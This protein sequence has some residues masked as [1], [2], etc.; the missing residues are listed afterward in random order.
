MTRSPAASKTA[1]PP[2]PRL[3]TTLQAA[4][5]ALRPLEFLDRC[6]RRHGDVFTLRIRRERPW[7]L[8][9]DPEHVKHV[10]TTEPALVGA[11]AAE[12]N[13]LLEPLLGPRSVM[14]LDEPQHLSDR[15]R[16][17][18][19]FHGRRM[20]DYGAMMTEVARRHVEDWPT[21][22]P[23]ELWPRMQ[24]ISL[25]VVTSAVFDGLEPER[26][27]LLRERLVELTNWINRPR[28][29][30]LLA[31]VGK[32]SLTSSAGFADAM[33]RVESVVLDEVRRRRTAIRDAA[34]DDRTARDGAAGEAGR[35]EDIHAML[36][37]S[38]G[39]D[40]PDGERKMRDELV[41]MLSDGPTATSLAWVFERL[42]RHPEKLARLREEVLRGECD[43][44]LDA[45]VKETLRL[46]PAV[47]LVMRRLIEPMRLGRHTIPADTIVAPC[48][49][50]M[51]RRAD[52]Y[53]DPLRF[54]PERFLERP[55]GTY[56][57]IPFG[58]GVRRC[59][60]ASFAQ[61]EMRRVIEVVVRELDLRAANAG[62]EAPVRSSVSFAPDGGA[63]V[64][65]TRR[66]PAP[67]DRQAVSG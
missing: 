53:R 35:H 44:Y 27:E 61:L 16:L 54:E 52:V 22:E 11:G 58:G 29:L 38:Y 7:V 64:I 23:F 8:L 36:E 12:A 56:T 13:P 55:E 67:S 34:S 65:A 20:R 43:D 17:L 3:P 21:S 32:R 47:P 51:H 49:Y 15:K 4:I 5:W 62:T 50:L 59:V 1:L 28:R 42:L 40:T 25:D 31:A 39:E 57:W 30:A 24:A 14:L 45:C 10:F 26:R 19:S 18:P 37:R 63:R 60:A 6:A 48:V 2:G 33:D 41:T 9:S 46:C 66:T